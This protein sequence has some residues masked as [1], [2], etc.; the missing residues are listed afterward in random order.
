VVP[1]I[2]DPNGEWR[3]LDALPTGQRPYRIAAGD[4]DGDGRAEIVV[5]A[6][7]SHHVNLW[8]S[9]GGA[10]ASFA[11]CPDL[12]VGTGPLDLALVDLVD[13]HVAPRAVAVLLALEVR[14]R[15]ERQNC[16]DVRLQRRL[17][18]RDVERYV[19]ATHLVGG[20]VAAQA[21]RV[22]PQRSDVLESVDREASE[23]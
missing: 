12:G 19:P 10:P 4:L 14:A 6:Q 8:T 7:N 18:P 13:R 1:W 17:Q 3:A 22:D 5:S 21:Q 20:H 2:H 9:R 23:Q 11:R 15:G 16:L